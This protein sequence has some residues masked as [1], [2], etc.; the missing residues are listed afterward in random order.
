MSDYFEW[1]EEYSVGVEEVDDDH[2]RLVEILNRAVHAVG[3]QKTKQTVGGILDELIEY[4]AFHFSHEEVLME[5]TK[6]PVLEHHRAE[7]ERLVQ[8]VVNFKQGYQESS[9]DLVAIANFLV[10]WL[11]DH[12]Q[13]EDARMGFYLRAHG[14]K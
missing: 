3:E 9:I 8:R 2:K 13:G 4:T 5:D 7:H 10:E 1:M 11:I 6:Y 14:I 12:I